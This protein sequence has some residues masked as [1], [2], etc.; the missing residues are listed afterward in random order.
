MKE[1]RAIAVLVIY[2]AVSGYH[3]LKQNDHIADLETENFCLKV[4]AQRMKCE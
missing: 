4:K 2:I 1:L 3:I